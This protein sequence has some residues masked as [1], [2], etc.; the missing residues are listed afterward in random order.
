MKLINFQ[1]IFDTPTVKMGSMNELGCTPDGR[2][3]E[4]MKTTEIISQFMTV[5]NP[6]NLDVDTVASS[7]NKAGQSVYILEAG[8][9]W[10]AGAYQDHWFLVDDGT[11]E[12]QGGK[13]KDNTA[14][15]LELYTDYALGTAL[16]VAG[17]SDIVI[18]HE[19]D[20]EKIPITV[21]ETPVKGVAQVAF[22]SGDYGW[23]L[24][25]GIGFV[26]AGEA[27]T[28]NIGITPGDNTEGTAIK[29]TTTEGA[30]DANS[31]ARCLVANANADKAC[32]ADI[33]II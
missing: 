29:S 19:P 9:A 16:T 14:D 24:K 5:S 11:G 17:V 20:A 6:A 21:E 22:A 31:F 32:M 12:G 1:S 15:T 23:F 8:A 27:I 10:T 28:I 13:I 2:I 7:T 33:N 26:L 3:W 4:Y 25:R 18:R 30:F